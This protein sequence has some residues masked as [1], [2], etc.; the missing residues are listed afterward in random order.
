MLPSDV[1]VAASPDDDRADIVA[2]NAIPPDKAGLDIGPVSADAFA[3]E[4]AAAETVFW[5]G[6]MGVF[7][8]DAF[9]G[10]S[11][12]VARAVAH[13]RGYTAIGGVD[14]ADVKPKA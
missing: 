14:T 12:A 10:G 5:N 6:P 1:V 2:A 3:R 13:S 11:R 4:I 7:E 9:A 8:K